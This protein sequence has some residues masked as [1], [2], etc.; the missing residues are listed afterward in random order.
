MALI[1]WKEEYVLGIPDVDRDHRELIDLINDLYEQ[2]Q[3]GRYNVNMNDFLG[4]LYAIVGRH[5]SREEEAMNMHK[6]DQYEEHKT[7]HEKLLDDINNMMY[8]FQDGVLDDDALMAQLLDKWFSDHF[9]AHDARLHARIPSD[10][11][12]HLWPTI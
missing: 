9:E 10:D 2:L 3:S 1:Q 5:F 6:Y 8:D 4:E 7:D 11:L 12:K